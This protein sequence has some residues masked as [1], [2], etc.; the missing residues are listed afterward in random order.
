MKPSLLNLFSSLSILL[1]IA[2]SQSIAQTTQRDNRPR[3]ASISGRVTVGGSPA[4]DAP[5]RIVEITR[6]TDGERQ[7][8]AGGA[9]TRDPTIF[10]ARTDSDGRY[11]VA[12]LAAGT[13]R[14]SVTSKVHVLANLDY[15][16]D[17]AKQI[18]LDDGEA[19]ENIDLAL[20]RG[21]VIM[22]RVTNAEGKPLIEAV[23]KLYQVAQRDGQKEYKEFGNQSH[24]MSRTDD[25]GVYRIYRLP[26]GR[27]IVS[28]G[29]D[30]G[31]EGRSVRDYRR[32][33]F[34]D[35]TSQ[36]KARIIEV[37][38]GGE[39]VDV[40]IRLGGVRRTYEAA[41]RLTEADTG[42]PIPRVRVWCHGYGKEG[43]EQNPSPESRTADTVTDSQG[44]FRLDGLIPGKYRA[45]YSSP[46]EDNEYYSDQIEF[47]VIDENV[48]GLEIIAKRGASI[49]GV[50]V[51]EGAADPK[52]QSLLFVKN[53]FRAEI[54]Q[55][56]EHGSMQSGLSLRRIEP[57]GEFRFS[58]LPSGGV[59]FRAEEW[60]VKSL[61]VL[62]V[63]HNGV[64][65]KDGIEIARGEQITGVRVV[66]A[67]ASGV[68][69]G[70]VKFA[71]ALPE[72]AEIHV[73]ATPATDETSSSAGGYSPGGASSTADEKG[74][75]VIERLL[76]GEYQLSA[77]V[78]FR[79]G[80]NSTMNDGK[81]GSPLQ[82]VT[83]TNAAESIVELT[84][85]KR[86]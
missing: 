76:P 73:S 59:W 46:H 53:S 66:F 82:R 71:G 51:I 36:E 63:E 31:Q 14:I 84:L 38:E 58:G 49:S 70:Q 41:G 52:L 57:N 62:R 7:V 24:Q 29:G 55:K 78:T 80:R 85:E 43:G 81:I 40:D 65:V 75:F 13:Y 22:G 6:G 50:A 45:S 21:G 18:T 30:G 61:R 60:Q 5:L 4:P 19:R 37:K 56:I 54:L 1:L 86:R 28:A 35:T 72:N 33:Y 2:A 16:L 69:R 17:P 23:V 48:E 11:R 68:I 39:T 74:R 34:G 25:R 15:D 47:E 20:A 10:V 42:K 44:N 8:T 26:A 32:T 77:Y 83:V 27:Y 67:Q 9:L 3:T 64:E 79:I 12:G